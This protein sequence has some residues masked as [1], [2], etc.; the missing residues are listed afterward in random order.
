MLFFYSEIRIW[1]SPLSHAHANWPSTLEEKTPGPSPVLMS[2]SDKLC[3]R[4]I[5]TKPS[6]KIHTLEAFRQECYIKQSFSMLIMQC[7]YTFQ[8]S[9]VNW[10]QCDTKTI[11][12]LNYIESA[13]YKKNPWWLSKPVGN[14]LECFASSSVPQVL[15]VVLQTFWDQTQF[16][17][18]TACLLIA[19]PELLICNLSSLLLSRTSGLWA[20]A[21]VAFQ[22]A[23]Q[24]SSHMFISYQSRYFTS[25]TRRH[26]ETQ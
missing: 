25:N 26:F 6:C 22:A 16:H 2:L 4:K 12:P 19:H 17:W 15:S 20:K 9:S 18:L 5:S 1:S 11:K 14:C 24:Q 13:I 3:H 21:N 10:E 7:L 23:I 8:P